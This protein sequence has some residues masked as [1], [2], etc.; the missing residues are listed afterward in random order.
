MTL[1][2]GDTINETLHLKRLVS[3]GELGE[4]FETRCGDRSATVAVKVFHPHLLEGG[5]DF[6]EYQMT[7]E[8]ICGTAQAHVVQVLEFGELEDERPYM[9]MPW[10]PGENLGARVKRRGKLRLAEVVLVLEQICQALDHLRQHGA[11]HGDLKPGHVMLQDTEA[12]ALHVKLLDL[13]T[14]SLLPAVDGGSSR[15]VHSFMAP[16]KVQGAAARTGPLD[17]YGMGALACLAL[18]GK[19]PFEG[20]A[21]ELADCICKEQPLTVTEVLPNLDGVAEVISRAMSRA[22]EGRYQQPREMQEAFK[23]AVKTTPASGPRS[24]VKP[25]P[26]LREDPALVASR[27]RRVTRSTGRGR[28]VGAARVPG[29]ADAKASAPGPSSPTG[30]LQQVPEPGSEEAVT[31]ASGMGPVSDGEDLLGGKTLMDAGP[32]R[33]VSADLNEPQPEAPVPQERQAAPSSDLPA[34]HTVLADQDLASAL[35]TAEIDHGPE[36][37]ESPGQYQER[38]TVLAPES[39]VRF[40]GRDDAEYQQRHTVLAPDTS[41]ASIQPQQDLG[42]EEVSTVEV[43]SAAFEH[44][45]VDEVH[46]QRH[47]VV[48]PDANREERESP[49]PA[50]TRGPAEGVDHATVLAPDIVAQ[51]EPASQPMPVIAE[52][53]SDTPAQASPTTRRPAPAASTKAEEASGLSLVAITALAAGAATLAIL[54]YLLLQ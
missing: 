17:I 45:S 21:G 32:A 39:R 31:K 48:A 44:P 34:G 2:V 29:A 19:P 41:A 20:A 33:A 12:G 35:A 50:P 18:T 4:V 24:A 25:D 10:I 23:E 40:R 28:I 49:L 43:Q 15:Q 3:R 9:V 22:P 16:E 8:M 46:S 14:A 54:L 42:L 7:M 51:E 13:G 52:E 1:R 36:A 38:H 37:G 11:V 53:Q 6:T 47:T 27:A 26:S 5:A 30:P